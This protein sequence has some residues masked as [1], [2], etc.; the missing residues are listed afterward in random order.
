[1]RYV[2]IVMGAIGLAVGFLMFAKDNTPLE[3]LLVQLGGV[4]LAAGMATADIVE[5]IKGSRRS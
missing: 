5:V 2:L 1:M 4:F 3:T